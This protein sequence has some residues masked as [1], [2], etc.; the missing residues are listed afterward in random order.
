MSVLDEECHRK[1]ILYIFVFVHNA[2]ATLRII[3]TMSWQNKITVKM[4]LYFGGRL[5]LMLSMNN[6]DIFIL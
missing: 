6:F 2:Y 3:S 4:F 1:H 5:K